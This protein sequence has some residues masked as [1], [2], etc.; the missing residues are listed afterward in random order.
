MSFI[1]LLPSESTPVFVGLDA[2]HDVLVSKDSRD[3]VHYVR[4]VRWFRGENFFL[5]VLT[6][7]GQCLPEKDHVGFDSFVVSC[8]HLPSSSQSLNTMKSY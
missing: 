4:R 7:A 1:R 3:G 8:E 2:K 5:Q 6:S